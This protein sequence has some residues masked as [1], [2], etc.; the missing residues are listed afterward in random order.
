MVE[1]SPDKTEVEGPIPSTRT[2][3]KENNKSSN[4]AVAMEI[5][6]KISGW[7]VGPI[8]VSLIVGRALD[9]HFGTKPMIL[10]SLTGLAFI[11]TCVG[12]IRVVKGYKKSL[13][14]I[15]KKD[16]I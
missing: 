6:T 9:N 13:Q 1:R 16:Q 10:L 14:N 12:M 15:D 4:W 3:D 5:F 2:M 8:I 7:I 11:A